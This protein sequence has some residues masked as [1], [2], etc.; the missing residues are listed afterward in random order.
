MEVML[1]YN[2][3]LRSNGRKEVINRDVR[4][5]DRLERTSQ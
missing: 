3:N 1:E 4:E 5:E 2:L